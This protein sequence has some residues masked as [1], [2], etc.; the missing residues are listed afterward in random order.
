M[1][2]DN[3]IHIR[4]FDDG[5]YYANLSA[6]QY[7]DDGEWDNIELSKEFYLYGPFRT[8]DEAFDNAEEEFAIIEYGIYGRAP[9]GEMEKMIDDKVYWI[10]HKVQIHQ[11]GRGEEIYSSLVR[12]GS[13]S[14]EYNMYSVVPMAWDCGYK[15]KVED[16][17]DFS[18]VENPFKEAEEDEYGR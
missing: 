13:F 14:E 11:R 10:K 15:I 17:I 1:S 9:S 2:A 18:I 16:I 7:W 8:F 3:F 4:K 5:F 6:S 12:I